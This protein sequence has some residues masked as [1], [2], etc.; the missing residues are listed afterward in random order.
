MEIRI[1]CQGF[2]EVE[3]DSLIELHHYGK[4]TDQHYAHGRNS[5]EEL[6]FSFPFFFWEH[7]GK[8]YI[9]DGHG[10]KQ[11]LLRMREEGFTIPPLPADPIFAK[12][13][14]EAAKKLLAQESRYKDIEKKG[15]D[16]FFLENELILTDIDNFVDI[17]DL[18]LDD[19]PKNKRE[20]KEIECPNCQHKFY[21][22]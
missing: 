19:S 7:E 18:V 22:K 4:L 5:I 6:G 12:D 13:R 2:T 17:P 3:L 16:D 21:P 8:K 11:I 14:K 15:L 1:E 10:R 20:P 9:L